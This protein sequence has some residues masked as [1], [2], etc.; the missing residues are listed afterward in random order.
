MQLGNTVMKNT[1]EN[2]RQN[3]NQLL[4]RLQTTA[5]GLK[6]GETRV[7][8]KDVALGALIW[9]RVERFY[10]GMWTGLM[11]VLRPIIWGSTGPSVVQ[12]PAMLQAE[13]REA[14]KLHSGKGPGGVGW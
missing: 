14:G 10:R 7:F 3:Q 11:D 8:R 9:L 12:P 1:G 2:C 5:C 6:S 4:F 13:G